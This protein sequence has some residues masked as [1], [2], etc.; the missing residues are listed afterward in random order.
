M[1]KISPPIYLFLIF[2]L[3]TIWGLINLI[4]YSSHLIVLLKSTSRP[5]KKIYLKIL[6]S[7]SAIIYGLS[8]LLVILGY[9]VSRFASIDFNIPLWLIIVFIIIF[10][11]YFGMIYGISIGM[12]YA[13]SVLGK[14]A[15]KLVSKS[16]EQLSDSE[17]RKK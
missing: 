7:F 8:V 5:N 16:L 10:V 1:N 6:S 15:G 12:G 3:P 9:G 14:P 2:G 13:L 11:P 17:H 4:K